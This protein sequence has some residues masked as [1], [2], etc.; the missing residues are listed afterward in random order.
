[1]SIWEKAWDVADKGEMLCFYASLG[2]VI[3]KKNGF[4][5]P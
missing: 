5:A 2:W 3:Y 1:M 4:V